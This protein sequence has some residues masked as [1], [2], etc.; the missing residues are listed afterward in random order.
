M[1]GAGALMVL[2]TVPSVE[3]G[4][5]LARA[6]VD[7]RLAACVNVVPEVTSIYRWQGQ[8][9]ETQEALLIVKTGPARYEAL[10]RRV[11]E[12]HPS[13]VPEVLALSVERGAPRYVQWVQESVAPE[14]R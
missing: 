2:V 7:E 3:V 8:R 5:D 11:L 13:S 9:E 14:G 6:L 1:S 10:E 12:L 4:R